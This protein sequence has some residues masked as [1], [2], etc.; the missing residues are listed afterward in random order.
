MKAETTK[1][2]F[3]GEL[4]A[5]DALAAAALDVELVELGA[6]AVAAVGDDEHRGVVAGDV[7]RHDL[8]ALA[9]LHAAHAGGRAAHRAHVVLGEADGLAASDTRRSRRRRWSG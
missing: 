7:A 5:L 9:H 4:D 8:V 3:A 6:L 1:P 2:F